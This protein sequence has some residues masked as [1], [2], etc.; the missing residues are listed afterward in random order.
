MVD[1]FQIEGLRKIRQR[2]VERLTSFRT[3]DVLTVDRLTRA[4]RQLSEWPAATTAVVSY[5][6]RPNG[7]ADVAVIV[8]E[9][10]LLPVSPLALGVIGGRAIFTREVGLALGPLTSGGDRVE[11]GWRFWPERPR[12]SAAML[13]PAPWG[14]LWGVQVSSEQQPLTAPVPL[15]FERH[16]AG[17][18]VSAWQTGHVRWQVGGGLDRWN[19]HGRFG[20]ISAGLDFATL[21]E[22]VRLRARGQSW[23]GAAGFGTWDV[24]VRASHSLAGGRYQVDARAATAHVSAS[25]PYDIWQ[26]GDNGQARP[27]LLRAHPLLRH[28]KLLASRLG[29]DVT[30][31]STELQRLFRRRGVSFG[32]AV[33]VDVGITARTLVGTAPFLDT[34]I[35]LGLRARLPGM[36]G[37][38][39]IDLAKG[40]RDGVSA[41]SFVFEP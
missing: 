19:S 34:D 4:R 30:T 35:G 15:V 24:S 14:G 39:R 10:D 26:A 28:G 36:A 12:Y 20:T 6:P 38:L 23:L 17:V 37:T 13:A 32:P 16:S 5:T 22:G 18:V 25:A 31:A 40:L 29:A 7:R 33:F 1:L 27:T 2:P 8:A 21:G 41:L 11:L 3:G 9:R